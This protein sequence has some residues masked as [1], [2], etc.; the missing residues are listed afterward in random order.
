VRRAEFAQDCRPEGISM[1]RVQFGSILV[2]AV[3]DGVLNLPL[4]A[5]IPDAN[6]ERYRELG[7][8]DAAG[9][10]AAQLTT[11]VI[12]AAGRLILVDTG[13][14]PDL[15]GLAAMGMTGEVGKLPVALRAAGIEPEA[16]DAVVMTH[17]HSD[18]I[19]WNSIDRDGVFV[20]AFPKARYIVPRREWEAREAIADEGARARSLQPVEASGQLTLVEDGHTVAPG[21]TL[22]ATPGH[23]P[24]HTSVLVFDGGSGGVI[25]G[26]AVHHPG[27]MENPEVTAVFDSDPEQARTTRRALVER[28]EAE[29]LVVLGGHFPPPTAGRV[30]RAEQKRRWMWMGS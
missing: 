3:S 9:M 8:V 25:T 15:G 22:L 5:A 29:G 4:A 18:H 24:G 28:A 30:V 26:D 21:V 16:V 13:I 14:G 1:Q 20:P 23:T 11:F 19:G 17:L 10:V 6:V 12:R 27:E 7:G 2:D